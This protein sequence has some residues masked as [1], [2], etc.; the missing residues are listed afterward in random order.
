MFFSLRYSP[1]IRTV[2]AGPPIT[3]KSVFD[4]RFGTLKPGAIN[5]ISPFTVRLYYNK[6]QPKGCE[7]PISCLYKK[8]YG[9]ARRS[10]VCLI[11]KEPEDCIFIFTNLKRWLLFILFKRNICKGKTRTNVVFF[12]LFQQTFIPSLCTASG[13]RKFP[14]L[15][16]GIFTG[17]FSG[18]PLEDG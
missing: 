5:T 15:F 4:E 3:I 6:L 9:F 10:N 12:H 7:H 8:F 14:L 13:S 1:S 18:R 16:K 2:S 17:K 11:L